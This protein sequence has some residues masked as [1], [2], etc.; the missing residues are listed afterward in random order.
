MSYV[1]AVD[2]GG[3]FCDCIIF[4]AAGAVTRAKAP[5]TPPDFDDGVLDA[6][7]EAARKLGR[8]L[9]AV[10]SETVL[11]AHGTTVATNALITRTGARVALLTTKGH[12]DVMLIG[13]TAQKVAGLSEEEIINVARLRKP[14]PLVPRPRIHG[15]DERI[16][17]AGRVVVPLHLDRARPVLDKLKAQGVQAVA[18]SFLWSFLNPAHERMVEAWLR[19][20]LPDVFVTTSSE[21]APVIR[22]YERTATTVMNAY[23]TPAVARYLERMRARL[24]EAGL[25]GAVAVMLSSGGLASVEEACRRGAALLVS[26]PAGGALG[27]QSLGRQLG[28]DRIL[29]TDVGGTSFDVGV[30]IGGEPG[31]SDGP[32]VDKFPLALPVIDVASIGAGGGSIAWVEEETGVLR[33][34][35]DSAGARPGPACYGMGGA[36][37][38]VTDANLVL[39]R[40]N[41]DYFLAGRLKLDPARAREAIRT[42]IAR[43]LDLSVEEAAAAVI[44]IVD[45][46]MADLIRKV[47]VDRGEDPGG[48]TVVSYG[49]AGGLH[50]DAFASALGCRAVVIPAVAAVFSAFGIASSD[51]K[52]VLQLSDPMRAPFDLERWRAHFLALEEQIAVHMRKQRLPIGEISLSRFVHLL[53]RG[54]VHTLRVPIDDVDLSAGDH[55]H[56]VIERFKELYEARFGQGTAYVQAGVEATSLSVEAVAALPKPAMA[57][58]ALGSEDAGAA[59]KVRRP[60]YLHE[61]G[62]F[63]EVPVYA[64]SL[65]QPGHRLVGP[66]LIEAEDTTVLVRTGHSLRVDGQLNL[67]IDLGPA[68]P[69]R[70]L[71][72][73]QEEAATA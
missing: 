10:L 40:L 39:G 12:E 46:Q 72:R 30:L 20:V 66:A 52:R 62:G 15:L 34:G 43:P 19:Q 61:S 31:Y 8:P 23:L 60:V 25:E 49:G 44:E 11:F 64:G 71:H 24:M 5:S 17:R 57:E 4:D 50:C 53:F 69:G 63:T 51:A 2:S 6:V 9:D 58:A 21:L 3:T 35:P 54:Q 13:R 45:A 59:L 22:E 14:K 37:P 29:T 16:D 48:F 18:V 28:I 36:E 65:L 42:R 26:G 38:T 68:G 33:V 73:R 56:R 47:T 32:I 7:A 1:I 55:G 41:P 27:A 70:P 67:H